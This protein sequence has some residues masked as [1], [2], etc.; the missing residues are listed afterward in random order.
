MAG[1]T[2]W[3]TSNDLIESVKRKISFPI[4]QV[5]FTEDDILSFA[6]EE[7]AISQVPSVMLYHEEYYVASLEVALATNQSRYA[8]PDRAIGLK[9]R[10]LFFKDANG[11]LSEM[12][13]VSAEDKSYW[14][15]TSGSTTSVHKYYL[16]GNFVVLTPDITTNTGS[17]VFYF[18]LRPNQL[19]LNERACISTSFQK[20]VTIASVI[21]DDVLTIG[22]ETFTAGTDFVIGGTDTIT[23]TNLT[24]A[25]NTNGVAT[26]TSSIGVITLV[27]DDVTLEITGS[28]A[29]TMAVQSTL[30]VNFDQ[31]PATYTDIRTN[32]V[33]DL[34]LAGVLID[35]LQTKPGHQ[36]I[37]Y[38]ILIP[39]G[40]ISG[41]SITFADGVVP[42]TFLV[43]DY[44]CLS[45]ECIIP[46]LPPDLH[47]GLAER[48]CARVQAA[49]GDQDGVNASMMKIKEIEG[50]QGTLLDQRVE[51]SPQKISGR[52]G[53]LRY[54]KR[55]NGRF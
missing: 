24:T 12:S 14:S 5:T 26:A 40:G 10:D 44:V 16:E 43:G 39:T 6:N 36:I 46:Q 34:F 51:G 19:V 11:N 25:I 1:K 42:D 41:T 29:L 35:F 18:Y 38:D 13:R 37:D 32:V 49:Q 22:D 3:F 31:V 8:I 2:P 28:D 54:N 7:M 23:A 9:L 4:S 55:G 48:T 15:G 47:N 30:T 50:A 27:Y 21:A 33:E 53:L 45:N 20:T 17:L 52:H